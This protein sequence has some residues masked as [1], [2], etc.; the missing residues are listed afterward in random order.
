MVF[1]ILERVFKN[2]FIMVEKNILI[3]INLCGKNHIW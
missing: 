2:I 1:S 3:Q